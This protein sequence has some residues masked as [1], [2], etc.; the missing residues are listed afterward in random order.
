MENFVREFQ[1]NFKKRQLTRW[2]LV[3]HF[4]LTSALFLAAI[5][6][7]SVYTSNEIRERK[8]MINEM[9]EVIHAK[10][11]SAKSDRLQASNVIIYDGDSKN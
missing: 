11:G 1:D 7:L 4:K 3:R 9:S 6:S 8:K 2:F 5:V 10:P